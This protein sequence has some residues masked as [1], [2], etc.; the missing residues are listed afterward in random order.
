MMM[1]YRFEPGMT[2]WHL[3]FAKVNKDKLKGKV[4]IGRVSDL[5]NRMWK[6]FRVQTSVFPVFNFYS[7]VL[8]SPH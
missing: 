1:P 2:R 4:A 6:H 8:H 7:Y 3:L 5:L